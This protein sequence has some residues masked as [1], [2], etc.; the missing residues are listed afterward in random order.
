MKL[1]A[2]KMVKHRERIG[3]SQQN[4]ADKSNVNVRTVQRA[5]AGISISNENAAAIAA[6][7]QTSIHSLIAHSGGSDPAPAGKTITL[8]RASSGRTLLD[9]LD[10][11]TMCR[12]E[13]DVEPAADNLEL[14]KSLANLLEANMPE[15][16][17]DEKL[18]WPPARKLA[19]RL[20]LIASLN[21]LMKS[22]EAGGI[23]VFVGETWLDALL[24]KYDP[25]EG[26]FYWRENQRATGCRA[27]RIVI[28]E[29]AGEKLTR[30]TLVDWPV[31]I[32]EDLDDE[33]PF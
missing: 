22:L 20:E 7:L 8:R 14:L 17:N 27:V 16:L 29:H 26:G 28:S 3:Y 1:D 13:C 30:S 25:Y 15:P 18:N 21:E 5:E 9:T 10:H 2:L 33:V 32:A 11:T 19:E 24:P 31:S 12:I 4:V 6:A 23:G